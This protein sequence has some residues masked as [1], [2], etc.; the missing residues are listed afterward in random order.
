MSK[1]A[2]KPEIEEISLLSIKPFA[3]NPR[4]ID[5]KALE[6]LR[7]SLEMFGYVD[8]IV[9]NKRNMVLVSGH[10]RLRILLEAGVKSTLAVV[11]DLDEL[12]HKAMC[13]TLNMELII[14]VKHV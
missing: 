11:V 8:L 13:L 1:I 9:V 5:Q 2:K 4:D 7:K 14:M 10:Q 6:G 3:D 12:A